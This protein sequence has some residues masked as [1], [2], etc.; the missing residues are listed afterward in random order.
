V[1][2][3]GAGLGGLG[4]SRGTPAPA[5]YLARATFADI[6]GI[7]EDKEIVDFLRHP[8]QYRRPGA[9]IPRGMLL[10]GQPG[11]GKPLLAR[12]VAGEAD[13]P[14]LLDLGGSIGG[15]P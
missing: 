6:A 11:T 12:A 3:P 2:P 4:R 5:R 10:P 15:W 8:D 13:A 14:F 7:D 1:V 9:Q